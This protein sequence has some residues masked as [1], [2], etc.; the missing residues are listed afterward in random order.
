MG[1]SPRKSLLLL[2]LF[3]LSLVLALSLGKNYPKSELSYGLTFSKKKASDLGFD[4]KKVYLS[5]LDEL[6]V[7][8]LRLAAYWDEVEPAKGKYE[9]ADLD[10]QVKE[11]EKRNVELILAVGSRLPRWPEC[12]Y[13]GWAKDSSKEETDSRLLNYIKETVK[14]Y[15]DSKAVKYWQVENEPFLNHFGECPNPDKNLLD[16]EIALV[17]SLDSREIVIT[18]SGELSFWIS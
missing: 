6:K 7:K 12:H 9:W 2:V 15:K 5:V 14:R 10:W 16:K 18:D 11:A 1:W 8:K 3:F 13:P 17:K 4:W